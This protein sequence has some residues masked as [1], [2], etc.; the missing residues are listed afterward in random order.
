MI[1]ARLG[2]PGGGFGPMTRFPYLTVPAPEPNCPDLGTAANI[3]F[4]TV[5]S[6]VLGWFA[7]PPSSISTT[8][9]ILR[10]FTVVETFDG[11][12]MPSFMGTADFDGDGRADVYEWS[13]QGEGYTTYLAVAANATLTAGPEKWCA[14]PRQLQL[15]DFT[16]NRAQDALI[17]YIE[18]C[19]DYSSGV[20][21]ALDN[22]AVTHLELDP[23]GQTTWSAK[24]VFANDDTSPTYSR[25][26]RPPA[27]RP[28]SSASATAPSSPPRRRWPT[29]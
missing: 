2:L 10:Q 26:T 14:N 29:T 6:L 5:Q 27:S 22:G 15:R 9:L 8:G 23:L 12:E 20:V 13:D 11:Q 1:N 4:T 25:S 28:T 19:D 17:S 7:G 18:Q 24:V 16:A 3:D 21:V